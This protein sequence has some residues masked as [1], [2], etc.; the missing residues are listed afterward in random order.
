[1][2]RLRHLRLA[3]V[4]LLLGVATAVQAQGDC[5]NP[6]QYP[7]NSITPASN[8]TV[9]TISGCSFE[10]EYS[11]ITGIY[12][13]ANYEFTSDAGSYI[14]VRQGTFDG[15]VIGQ[16]VSPV[17]V[18]AVDGTDLF[19]H[20]N[21]DD[22][23]ST[24]ADCITTTVQLLLN[25]TL[26]EATATLV[27]DC[28][29][30]I[31][32]ILVDVTST[33]DGPTVNVVYSEF[34]NPTALPGVGVGSYELGP[35]F[36]GQQISVSVEHASDPLCNLQLGQFETSGDCPVTVTC[37][38]APLN[39]SYCY[40]NNEEQIWNY[41]ND[42]S[43]GSLVLTFFGGTIEAGF[44]DR[45]TI[46][47]GTD[48][49][50]TVLFTNPQNSQFDLSGLYVIST[51]G[52]FHIE[53]ITSGFGSCADNVTTEWSWQVQ[54]LGCQ[55]PQATAT[56]VDDCANNQFSI[57]V[58]ITSL[59][60]GTEVSLLYTVNGG[61]PT[62]QSGLGLGVATIGPFAIN[63][64]V[65][66]FVQHA[67]NSDCNLSL[68]V[69]TDS[70]T[71]PTLIDCG[72]EWNEVFCHGN[73]LDQTWYYQGTGAFPLA[74]VFNGGSLETCC[75]RLYVYDG[76]DAT[77]PLL[78][79]VGGQTGD[80]TGLTYISTNPGHSLT[81]RLTTD[82]S[83]SCESG[84]QI[85]LD[86]TLSCLDCIGATGTFGIVQD[87]DNFQY[88]V[89]VD[90]TSL[91][92]ATSMDI[93]NTAGLPAQTVTAPGVYQVGPITSGVSV[94]VTVVNALN[95][96]CSLESP[97]LVNPLCPTVLCGSA[98]L[99]QTYCYQAGENRAWA[100]ASPDGSGTI[101]LAFDI[102]TIET[103]FYDNL[104]IYDGPDATGTLLFEHGDATSNLGPVGS[105]VAGVDYDYETV[106]VTTTGPNIYMT[107]TSD[108]SVQCGSIGFDEWAFNVQCVGCSTPGIAYNLI[109][110]CLN[111]EYRTEVI[112]TNEP[113]TEGLTITNTVTGQVQTTASTGVITFGPYNNDSLALFTVVDGSE[114]ACIWASDSLTYVSDSCY[115]VS[116]GFDNYQ[117]C[118]GNDED[119]WYTFKS[120]QPVPTTIS[121]LQGNMVTGDRI[122]IYNGPN[123]NS[124]VIYQ[125]TNGGNLAGFAVNSQNPQNIITLRIQSN[126]AGSCADGQAQNELRWFVG[127]GAVGM[128][129]LGVNGFSAFPN[130]T[131]GTLFIN[132]GN[133]SLRSAM[134]RVLDMSGRAVIQERINIAAGTASEVDM[135]GLQTG[136]YMVQL[137][138]SEWTRTQ[139]V[140]VVR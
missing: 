6:N 10:E 129:E 80:L 58:D 31:F 93:V 50:G 135:K 81:I 128:E 124:N 109:P 37:G 75:D 22:Q 59:G 102:G 9:T 84:A 132:V 125:G 3:T 36:F 45:L 134:V 95:S 4:G 88:F 118:Y 61:A 34:G 94:Q 97:T 71:C 137:V 20:W 99:A 105:A 104:R 79:P 100:Y 11:A 57:D 112:I 49:T 60:D 101:R 41:Q 42:G 127:C 28:D 86:Y 52:F 14:T 98:P 107:L 123:E 25:C 18:T 72:T 116:C 54:C 15:P 133:T 44:N 12:A 73:N 56:N 17:Q 33:G 103:N 66:I 63:D 111:R 26:P 67:S 121:F 32:T 106:D 19:P 117:H 5:L 113:S 119:R 83:V 55:I 23:C 115:I 24:L 120:A 21:V 96:L 91:G 87:C 76:P 47:D 39:F 64:E 89:S 82:G 1:M 68:G 53:L 65:T 69:V 51:T 40:S 110:D 62:T 30:Q 138:T 139:R 38:S 114:P 46:Y 74:L 8:G 43:T 27:E 126:A 92:T 2:K 131:E 77:A 16:G 70:G 122:V 29:Q 85:A 78:T 48:N 130:P 35:F 13:G 7:T 140:Q 136:Q 90:L 108:G